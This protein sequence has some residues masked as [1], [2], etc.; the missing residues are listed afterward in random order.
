M[1]KGITVTEYILS[2][3][4]ERPE[5]RGAFT[6]ILSE[7]TVAAKIIAQKVK[8]ATLAEDFDFA[9][10]DGP[11]EEHF[12]KLVDFA[13]GTIKNRVSHLPDLLQAEITPCLPALGPDVNPEILLSLGPLAIEVEAAKQG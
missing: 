11:D 6:A 8:R 2:K 12:Q 3:Q 9:S 13:D 10:S 7:L 1:A 5:A 4:R